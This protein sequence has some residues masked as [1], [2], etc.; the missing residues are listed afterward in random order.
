MLLCCQ[1]PTEVPNRLPVKAQCLR[2][3]PPSGDVTSRVTWW[4]RTRVNA[5]GPWVN[6][7]ESGKT[8]QVSLYA[9]RRC[10]RAF[11][12]AQFVFCW[13]RFVP[14]SRCTIYNPPFSYREYYELCFSL[15]QKVVLVTVS[16]HI[17]IVLQYN[18]TSFFWGLSFTFDPNGIKCKKNSHEIGYSVKE[19]RP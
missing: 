17:F 5:A 6:G 14:V 1:Q 9:L 8:A 2:R 13:A 11:A 7:P 3:F 15:P 18:F 19:T 4:E 16:S 12:S 10:I